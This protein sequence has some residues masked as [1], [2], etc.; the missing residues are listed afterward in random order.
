MFGGEYYVLIANES[1]PKKAPAN[2]DGWMKMEQYEAIYA[3]LL[4]ADN[5]LIGG[6]VYNGDYVF[7]KNGTVN[8]VSSDEYD[9]FL[10]TGLPLVDMIFSGDSEYHY[11]NTFIPNYLVDFSK[12]R[13]WFGNGNTRILEN[14]TLLSDNIIEM[15]NTI[16]LPHREMKTGS[17][18][19]TITNTS[20]DD[21]RQRVNVFEYDDEMH[22]CGI[23]L[24]NVF[25]KYISQLNSLI[26]DHPNIG[27]CIPGEQNIILKLSLMDESIAETNKW[28]KGVIYMSEKCTNDTRIYLYIGDNN[29]Y[30]ELGDKYFEIYPGE[31][32]EY[33]FKWSGKHTKPLTV[34]DTNYST[35]GRYSCK[36]GDIIVFS[37]KSNRWKI[38]KLENK[39]KELE[40]QISTLLP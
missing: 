38:T 7:S 20:W 40:T 10:N 13:A 22:Y 39:I 3:K 24:N 33:L 4:V 25:Y 5:G 1:N 37:N 19:S 16:Y 21:W 32:I 28:Y 15:F 8:N 26:V 34:V 35:G 12:G 2:D 18:N 23:T 30:G 36:Y 31:K 14:G 27:T 9:K 29:I 11:Y 6:S 17:T